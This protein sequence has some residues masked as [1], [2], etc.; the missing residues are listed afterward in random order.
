MAIKSRTY[1]VTPGTPVVIDMYDFDGPQTITAAPGSGGTLAIEYSTT[2]WA[3]DNSATPSTWIAWPSGTVSA[4][5]SDSLM[6]PVIAI[7][8]TATTAA[9]TVEVMG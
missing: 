2:P 3:A 5:T 1:T 6:S 7:K 4:A 8:A 9:G